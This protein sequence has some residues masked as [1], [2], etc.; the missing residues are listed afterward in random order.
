MVGTRSGTETSFVGTVV[1]LQ[2]DTKDLVG[3]LVMVGA[4][5]EEIFLGPEGVSEVRRFVELRL[6]AVVGPL[7]TMD[8]AGG[9]VFCEKLNKKSDTNGI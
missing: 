1:V 6:V 2:V 4:E 9:L 8:D 3:G 5:R 7:F